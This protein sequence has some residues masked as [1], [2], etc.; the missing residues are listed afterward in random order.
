MLN[1]ACVLYRPGDAIQ[2]VYLC[3]S[4]EDEE[5]SSSDSLN[6]CD[7]IDLPV[8][9][10]VVHVPVSIIVSLMKCSTK[11]EFTLKKAILYCL[12][13]IR[14]PTESAELRLPRLRA[15][16]KAGGG[17][18]MF[19]LCSSTCFLTDPTIHTFFFISIFSSTI[20]LLSLFPIC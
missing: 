15:V 8:D 12:I 17:S 6:R 19:F 16:L 7:S 4:D 13:L 1:S 2:T 18:C 5:P 10:P 9:L 20:S 14:T 3:V 11:E